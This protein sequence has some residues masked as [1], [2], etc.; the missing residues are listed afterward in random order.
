MSAVLP[1]PWNVHAAPPTEYAAPIRSWVGTICHDPG[2]H[3]GTLTAGQLRTDFL[4][5][6]RSGN[7]RHMSAW[8]TLIAAIAGGV[9]ALA[10]QYITKSRDARTRTGELIM[11]QCAQVVALSDDFRVRVW[12]ESQ[13]HMKGRVDAWDLSGYRH[14][15]A[16]LKILCDDPALLTALEEMTEAGK[17]LGRYWRLGGAEKEGIETRRDRDKVSRER[18]IAASAKIVRRRLSR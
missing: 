3:P 4:M 16:R 17:S 12:E 13:L 5:C 18:F 8:I 15:A 10:G 2:S 11:E 1:A 6:G 9:I 7:I 14:A